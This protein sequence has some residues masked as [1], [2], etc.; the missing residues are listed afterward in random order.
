MFLMK[1]QKLIFVL[2][3]SVVG[4]FYI[5]SAF[6]QKNKIV[7]FGGSYNDTGNSFVVLSDPARF[8]FD[9]SCNLG[10]PANVPPYDMLDD[11]KMPDGVYA[12]GGHHVTNGATWVEILARNWG[13]AGSTRPALR[14]DGQNAGNFAIGGAR[15]L[16]F[17]CRF[18]LSDQFYE[19][20]SRFSESSADTLFVF[21]I[22]GNDL[23][24]MMV[25]EVDPIE[26]A[27]VIGNIQD[28]ILVL[29]SQGARKFLLVNVP[30]FGQTPAVQTLE[31][32]FPGYNFPS[33]A[34]SLAIAFNGALD[35]LKIGLLSALPDIEVHIL[36]LYDLFD[37]MINT[38]E[39]YG[40]VVTDTP[41]ITPE[42]EPY[43]CSKPDTYLFWDGLH[44]TKAVH[45]IAGY[46]AVNVLMD[47][48]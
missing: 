13:Q 8:G 19:Y 31:D 32:L 4:I 41:C 20:L 14:N 42:V 44:P 46:E 40:L 43:K 17:P 27:T 22:G 11:L 37:R 6:A 23:R 26:I 48:P 29:Y 39:D 30:N 35:Q 2:I 25:G 21:D 34:N 28:A 36:D 33:I 5:S 18:N 38:P 15:A 16:D 10:S 12:T 47:T 1:H 45:K 3:L 9:E 7:V 24:D